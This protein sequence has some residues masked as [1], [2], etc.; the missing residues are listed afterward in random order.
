MAALLFTL[1]SMPG[2]T[3]AVVWSD[4]FNQA[5]GSSP[6]ATKWAY[7]LGGGG[8]GNNE[9]E[10]YTNSTDNI[11]VVADSAATDG[12]ALVIHAIKD[13]SGGYTSARIKTQGKFT[14]KYGRVEARL[15]VASG[16]GI[17]PAFWMLGANIDTVSWPTCGEIDIMETI[18]QSPATAYGT[19]HGPGYSGAQGLQGK[20][21]LTDGTHFDTNYH[22]FAI[23]W[24]P[25]QIKWSV[26]GTVYHTWTAG[27]VP[28]GSTWVYDNS[29]FFIILNLAI[30][31][32]F[33]GNPDGTTAFPQSYSIDYVRVY[34][35]PPPAVGQVAAYPSTGGQINLSWTPPAGSPVAQY[36]VERALDSAFTQTVTSHDV[37]AV[38]SYVD[39]TAAQGTTYYYRVSVVSSAG[40]S[41]PSPTVQIAPISLAPSGVTRMANLS[42]RANV[43]AGDSVLIGGVVIS[44]SGAKTLLV[45][46][47]GPALVPFGVTTAL[48]DPI[49]SVYDANS[50]L[51]AINDNWSDNANAS[52]IISASAR[53]GAFSLTP[54]SKDAALLLTLPPGPYTVSV[55]GANGTSGVALVEV[56][57]ISP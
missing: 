4:E 8:W 17:W 35:V 14:M 36:R 2:A 40:V 46:G 42:A 20:D 47:I 54:S 41:D 5:A 33:P 6:D 15:K 57:E 16:K 45:R 11:S 23:D 12:K 24:S 26:D 25:G 52:D 9:L 22:V 30:G 32:A 21:V 29:P 10:T 13:S 50:H 49:V 18:G 48:A 56:Y 38:T 53:V 34:A 1:R 28:A 51:I 3:P 7:D 44:G 39:T 55:S 19:L 27:S 37:G 31:G 43:G